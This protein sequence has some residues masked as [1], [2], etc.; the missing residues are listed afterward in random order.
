MNKPDVHID[1]G[2][3]RILISTN[4]D[5]NNNEKMSKT[6]DQFKLF[7]ETILSCDEEFDAINQILNTIST[8]HMKIRLMIEHTETIT[9][10][11]EYMIL[12]DQVILKK[13]KTHQNKNYHHHRHHHHQMIK[14]MM[15]NISIII[16]M[17]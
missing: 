5:E 11:D 2:T 1:D 7:H 4:D 14:I 10:Q 15:L 17:N 9:N 12:D 16:K 6:L 8:Q 13:L 3:N